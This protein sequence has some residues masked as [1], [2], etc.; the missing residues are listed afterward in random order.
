MWH[1]RAC[2]RRDHK[3]YQYYCIVEF[4]KIGRKLGWTADDMSP[5]GETKAELI[6]TLEMMLSDVKHYNT[7]NEERLTK[8]CQKK[9]KRNQL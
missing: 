5:I 4:F 2:K 8:L 6:H 7:F 9:Q 1:Y 3:G